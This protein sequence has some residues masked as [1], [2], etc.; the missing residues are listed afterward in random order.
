MA[1]STLRGYDNFFEG[2]ELHVSRKG[3]ID[4]RIRSTPQPVQDEARAEFRRRC[5]DLLCKG[6][7]E[8]PYSDTSLVLCKFAQVPS[9]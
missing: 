1:I 5:F 6:F 8:F 9:A 3:G 4:I 7:R 2:I